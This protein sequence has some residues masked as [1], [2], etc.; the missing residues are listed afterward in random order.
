MLRDSRPKSSCPVCGFPLGSG[1]SC[2]WCG[3][4]DDSSGQDQARETATY[5]LN[6]RGRKRW[7]Q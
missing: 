3:W 7:Q 4:G 1:V 6:E 5:P 2:S